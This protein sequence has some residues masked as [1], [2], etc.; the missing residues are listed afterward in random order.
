MNFSFLK[1]PVYTDEI[2][3]K[4]PERVKVLGYL[5]LLALTVYRVFQR[6][7][8]QHITEQQPMRGAGG[9]ILKKPTG[10]AIFHI[11]KYLQVVVLR[12]TNG[13]RIRQFDQSLTKE[14]RR[15]LTSLDLD[16][17]IYLG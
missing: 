10:E 3:L 16:E 11:F 12:G 9:R 15:V 2:Y 17:S 4:K 7:I 5:F 1:D 6:R 14:Q 13:T 8:R